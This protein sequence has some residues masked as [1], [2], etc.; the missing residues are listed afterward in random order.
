MA[1]AQS[2]HGIE[3]RY[4]GA[5]GR[6]AIHPVFKDF[7]KKTNAISIADPGITHAAE[8]NDGKIMFGTMASLDKI[9]YD[10]LCK[11]PGED[12]LIEAFNESDL[13]AMVN[14]TMI[15]YLTD[16]FKVSS[17]KSYPHVLKIEPAPSSLTSPIPR[18][19]PG[20]PPRSPRCLFKI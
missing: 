3:V 17:K 6:D 10:H 12:K 5:I 9:T 20:R 14:W 2:A 16:V 11:L 4:I 19:A 18:N 13:I 15:P 7:A 8:F 1:N